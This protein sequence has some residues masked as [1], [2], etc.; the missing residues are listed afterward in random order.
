ML[1]GQ[2]SNL[3]PLG[4]EPSKLP[5]LT[6]RKNLNFSS[7]VLYP[8]CVTMRHVGETIIETIMLIIPENPNAIHQFPVHIQSFVYMDNSSRIAN[9]GNHMIT[10]FDIG[11]VNVT[12]FHITIQFYDSVRYVRTPV[13]DHQQKVSPM[14]WRT[15]Q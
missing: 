11:K 2:E 7:N 3:R 12:K 8:L 6:P 9:V 10:E 4:Y 5:L 1:R 14:F 13:L 15:C